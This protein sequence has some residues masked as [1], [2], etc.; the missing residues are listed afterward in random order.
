MLTMLPIIKLPTLYIKL[1][2]KS[3]Y[4][5]HV[6]KLKIQLKACVIAGALTSP[7]YQIIEKMQHWGYTNQEYILFVLYA[8]AADHLLGSAKH[9]W[10]DKDFSW[11]ENAKGIVTKVGLVVIV[12]VLFEGL[13]VIVKGDSFIYDYLVTVLRLSVFLYP[14]GSALGNCSVLSGGRF[15]PENL[16]KRVMNFN[17]TGNINE[18]K[19]KENE[20][21]SPTN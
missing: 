3:I 12:G 9:K 4:L 2:A 6:G 14:A 16:L 8:I 5:I 11:K 21:Q 13:T 18:F 10:I 19:N 17:K 20:E 7:I 1:L 15:P